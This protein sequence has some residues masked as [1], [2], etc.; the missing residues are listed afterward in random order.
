MKQQVSINESNVDQVAS[1]YERRYGNL[2]EAYVGGCARTAIGES[3][4]NFELAALG[5][6][7]DQFQQYRAFTEANASIGSLGKLPQVALDVITA[8]AAD[9]IVP[10]LASVQPMAEEHG[11]AYFRNVV[12]ANAGGGYTAGQVISDPMTRDNPGDGTFG[13]ARRTS[14]TDLVDGQ[15]EYVVQLNTQVRPY[16]TEILVDTYGMGKDDGQGN[17]AGFGIQGSVDYATG[18][19]T[20]KVLQTV[21]DATTQSKK[22]RVTYNL[23]VDA[24]EEID[25]IQSTLSTVDVV[26]QITALSSDIGAFTNFAFTQRFGRSATDE[27]AQDLTNE[28]T[29]LLNTRAVKEIAGSYKQ[30]G[31]PLTWSIKP[32]SG[33][34]YAEHKLTF[35]DAIASAEAQLH[36]ASGVNGA[37]RYIVGNGAAAVLRGMPD[38]EVA[39]DAATTSVG[40]YGYYDG[41]PVIRATGVV[42]DDDMYFVANSGNYFNAPLVYAPY[43]PL[44]I[45]STIQDSR[46]PFR[47]RT[48][49]GEWSAM[50]AVNP[51]L[52]TK[53]TITRN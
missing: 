27:V 10:L 11:I 15:A 31:T 5:R 9:S 2:F 33:V 21:A 37:N 17:I 25:R 3:V 49:A 30:V 36:A 23:D 53:L 4:S 39:S 19:V 14:V 6:Q 29:R 46:N 40:L 45:T 20:V 35:V 18:K 7:L 38:F 50:K 47:S 41:I 1:Q 13:S 42:A 51:N 48:A 26:A 22:L 8:A 28:L 16:Q 34:S 52:V 32:P 44:M 43:M 12:A 24:L